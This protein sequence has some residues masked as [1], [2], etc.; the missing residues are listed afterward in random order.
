MHRVRDVDEAS[1][2]GNSDDLISDAELEIGNQPLPK[3]LATRIGGKEKAS[4]PGAEA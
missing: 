3:L 4:K 1:E 2:D